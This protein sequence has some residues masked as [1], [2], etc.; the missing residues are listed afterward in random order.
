[1][2]AL[3][4]GLPARRDIQDQRQYGLELSLPIAQDRVVPF[5]VKDGAVFRIVA[6]SRNALVLDT[7]ALSQR[8]Q[9]DCI[10]IFREHKLPI[11][12][13]PANDLLGLPSKNPLCRRR[14]SR[15]SKVTVPLNDS[16]RCVLDMEDS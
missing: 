9:F 16:Q 12:D 8:Q 11:I 14:P 6:V 10:Q 4:L 5:A 7:V 3:L 15:D 1:M 2:G 13:M